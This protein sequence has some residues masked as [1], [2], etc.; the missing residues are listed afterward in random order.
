MKKETYY[1]NGKLLITGEYL[2]LNGAK[3]L[4]VPT[5]FGQD[6]E[7][8]PALGKKIYWKSYDSDGIIWFEDEILFD[9]IIEKTSYVENKIK[10]TLVEILHHAYLLNP[11]F[12]IN[13]EGYIIETKLTFPRL[14]GLG[15][16]STLINNL[17][18][19]LSIDSFE[20]LKN[21][22]GG[23]GY[24]IACAQTNQSIIYHLENEKPFFETV[25]FNP[26]FKEHIYFVYLN[27]KQSSKSAI[28]N[29]LN[30]QFSLDKVKI[31]IDKI[32]AFV[33]ETNNVDDF[34]SALEKH[35]ILLSD[36]LEQLTVKE[37]LFP[38]F[39]G[40]V[41]SLGAWG[42]DFVMVVSKENPLFYFN[43]KGYD[44]IL[45]YEEMVL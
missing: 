8:T 11:D 9:A 2:V 35:E 31:K 19:W 18:Q 1:S 22:F 4:A 10:N 43:E 30:K 12:I 23:S 7:V 28:N 32:T 41:K 26:E 44:T 16:S 36:I 45:K 13:T 14:W 38:D 3:S 33:S 24:D 29:Y 20:L 17:G 6:L 27:K 39:K 40:T 42:G 37:S 15:T 5:K 25:E 21:S 34:M